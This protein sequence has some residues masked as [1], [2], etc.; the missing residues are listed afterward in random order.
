M[1]IYYL[2][3]SFF[4]FIKQIF[5]KKHYDIIFYAPSHFNRGDDNENLYFKDL[6]DI[7]KQSNI[8]FI[9]F[10]EPDNYNNQE[11]SNIAIPFDF[12]YYLVVLLRKFM[13]SEMEHVKV[14]RKIGSFI[15]IF[16]FRKISFDNYITLSQSMISFFSGIDP[17]SKKFDLQH[18]TIHAKKKS[19]LYD[20]IPSKNLSENNVCILLSGV[21]FKDILI[22]ND[23][24]KYFINNS[25]V[26]GSL[27]NFNNDFK[28][29]FKKNVLVS[30]Q[31]TDDHTESENKLIYKELLELIKTES[32]FHF[33][34]RLHPRFNNI[35]LD[36]LL[37]LSNTSLIGGDIYNNFSICSFHLTTY[38]TIAFQAAIS[39]IPTCFIK[40]QSPKMDIFSTQYK[41]P[42]F[43]HSL[44]DL[45]NDYDNC[46]IKVRLWAEFFYVPFSNKIFLDIICNEN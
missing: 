20:G 35:N 17:N 14:D 30:L 8:S 42:Y 7:C 11:R 12:I 44:N 3:Y 15:K 34:L 27:L 13:G 5:S 6:L 45:Y 43:N 25:R 26:I 40:I 24:T 46:S 38:S 21:G 33:Y 39:S 22:K 2:M 4:Y 31:F 32:S 10:E 23:K 36:N 28:S 19:Y 29:D 1:K 37:S 41:Y 9:Y 16:F 18:G